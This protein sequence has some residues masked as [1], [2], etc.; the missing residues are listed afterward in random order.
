MNIIKI[1][2]SFIT[3]LSIVGCATFNETRL[4]S[5][6]AVK[7]FNSV[8]S[9]YANRPTFVKLHDYGGKDKS[10]LVE[11]DTYHPSHYSLLN[12]GFDYV[13]EYIS[14][15]DKYLKWESLAQQRGDMLTKDIGSSYSQGKWHK[16]EFRFYSGN[17]K[18]HYLEIS[19]CSLMCVE[20]STIQYYDTVAAKEL[21][22]LLV[23]LK[24][25]DLNTVNS[26]ELYQ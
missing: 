5:S 9:T 20:G 17:S 13:D 21:R 23:N 22:R 7:E 15:I 11:M 8:Y 3:A 26:E 6:L 18:N 25:G 1:V 2:V 10:L 12:F 14:H 19:N 4:S 24:N 16:Y